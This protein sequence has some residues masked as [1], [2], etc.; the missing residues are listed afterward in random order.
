MTCSELKGKNLNQEFYIDKKKSFKRGEIDNHRW[1]IFFKKRISCC[2][3][4][5]TR[6]VKEIS[7]VWNR[8]TGE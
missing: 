6:N 7:S 1:K 3:I 4:F 5:S 2:K 8:D